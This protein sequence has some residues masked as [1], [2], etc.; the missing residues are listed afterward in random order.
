VHAS[1]EVTQTVS[2]ASPELAVSL[3]DG[4]ARR[5]GLV[6]DRPPRRYL[7]TDA[8]AVCNYVE[9][10]RSSGDGPHLTMATRLVEQVH[11]VL[12][13]HR[14]DDPRQGWISGLD[15]Q[16]GSAQPTRGGLRIGKELPERGPH[17]P[18]DDRLEWDRDGQ[19]FHYLT[20]WMHALDQMARTTRDPRYNRWARELAETAHAAFVTGTGDG[21]RMVWKR[22]IDLSRVLIPSMGQHDPLD[23]CIT[24]DQLQSTARLLGTAASGPS[25]KDEAEDFGRIAER[26][27]WV[28]TDSLGLG[29]LLS[30]A[31]R[32]RQLLEE[33]AFGRRHWLPRL[34]DAARRGLRYFVA[35]R[36]LDHPATHR[37]AFRELG[38]AV[39]LEGLA[40]AI[41][42]LPAVSSSD[43]QD[44]AARRELRGFLPLAQHIVDFWIRRENR[45][46]RSWTEHEDINDVMLATALMPGGYLTLHQ[47]E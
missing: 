29:G 34:L 38:L 44:E 1:P 42:G 13:R 36:E 4:F 9:L 32:V 23:G 17:E 26:G 35:L 30:D 47:V 3:M 10:A 20:R 7:W 46:V 41:D 15:E 6:S 14:Q 39:G 40:K 18:V 19:Y 27:P 45:R 24:C 21:R 43:A 16:K 31:E 5:T 28:S 22:S 12:G 2:G 37:L 25:V 11:D 8:F 33:D